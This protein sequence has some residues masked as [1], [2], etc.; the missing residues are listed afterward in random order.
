LYN[1]YNTT[2]HWSFGLLLR[3]TYKKIRISLDPTLC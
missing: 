3:L 1:K 2:D